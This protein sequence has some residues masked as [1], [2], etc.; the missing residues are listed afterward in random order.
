MLMAMI[1]F[2]TE[3]RVSAISA[4]ASRIGGIDIRPS[5]TRIT[6]ASSTRT[7]PESRPISV[8]R[9]EAQ[10]ATENPTS[11]ETRDPYITRE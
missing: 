2:C 1:T 11:S 7:K 8:P 3:A 5:I 10:N 6:T 9:T 4:I